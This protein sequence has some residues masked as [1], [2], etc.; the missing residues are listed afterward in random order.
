VQA[1]AARVWAGYEALAASLAAK[2]ARIVV[3]PEKIATLDT[4]VAEVM[5]RQVGALAA[6]HHIWINV[7]VALRQDGKKRN[8]SWLFAPD[9]TLT[10]S[11]QKHHLAPPEHG[12]VQGAEYK[13]ASIDGAAYGMAIC[14]DMHFS[15]FGRAYGQRNAAV[16]LVPAWDFSVDRWMGARMTV[17]RGV[18]S[19]FAVVRSAREGLLTVSDAHGRM[20]GE[21]TSRALPGETLLVSLPVGEPVP[22]LH[23]KI[24]DLAGWLCVIAAA[25]LLGL[26][27][28]K[29][30]GAAP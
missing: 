4:A 11:Y 2:G 25:L 10:E 8:L 16:L 22:T 19:G 15:E 21:R 13:L 23:Q 26:A 6:Q 17:A 14:K 7:G 12:F 3:L 27:V 28:R 18:E 29:E 20:L 1:Q 5:Q 24:G 9:G 30:P